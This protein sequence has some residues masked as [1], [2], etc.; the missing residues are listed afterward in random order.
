MIP[1][2]PTDDGYQSPTIEELEQQLAE[3][4]LEI[5]TMFSEW[6]ASKDSTVTYEAKIRHR[7]CFME[8][9]D[10]Y[11]F[12]DKEGELVIDGKHKAQSHHWRLLYQLWSDEIKPSP[13]A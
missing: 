1:S 3:G 5:L 9:G 12:I 11:L 8:V 13:T 10:G 2:P 7:E 4:H 6:L